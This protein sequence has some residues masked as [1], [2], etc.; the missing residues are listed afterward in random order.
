MHPTPYYSDGNDVLL[1]DKTSPAVTPKTSLLPSSWSACSSVGLGSR[2][3]S[4]SLLLN[5][6]SEEDLEE[7]DDTGG[8]SIRLGIV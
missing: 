8:D 5:E 3:T 2:K 4:K 7:F 1:Q 6:D